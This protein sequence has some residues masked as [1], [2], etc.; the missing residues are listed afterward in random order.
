MQNSPMPLRKGKGGAGGAVE[1][2]WA[3][4]AE[5]PGYP[6]PLGRGGV[7]VSSHRGQPRWPLHRGIPATRKELPASAEHSEHRDVCNAQVIICDATKK[8]DLD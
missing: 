1:F 4:G 2:E 5:S 7:P 8:A 3:R 6:P